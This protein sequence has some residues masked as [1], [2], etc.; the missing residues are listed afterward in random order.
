M[1][2]SRRGTP[3]TGARW[4]PWT[5]ENDSMTTATSPAFGWGLATVTN[6]GKV[7]DVWYPRPGL[8][9]PESLEPSVDLSVI[10]AKGDDPDRRVR[11]EVS[12]DPNLI[13]LAEQRLDLGR[14]V[15]LSARN[16]Q[17][18]DK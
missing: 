5:A 1:T 11:Q 8:G 4:R 7:L 13:C 9:E 10:A 14:H 16:A 6:D 15:T 12:I 17:D 18:V 2:K 3:A